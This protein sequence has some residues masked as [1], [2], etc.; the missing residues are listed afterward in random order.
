MPHGEKNFIFSIGGDVGGAFGIWSAIQTDQWKYIENA[1][2]EEELYDLVTDPF[3]LESQ[4][5][6]PNFE[7]KY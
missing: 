1:Y 4:H 6:N 2:G 7:P 5:N 3:E